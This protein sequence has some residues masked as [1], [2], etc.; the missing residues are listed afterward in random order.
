[1][2]ARDEQPRYQGRRRHHLLE[3][4]QHQQHL[5]V[6][7][8]LLQ[9]LG[10][11]TGRR[12][13][14]SHLLPYHDGDEVGLGDGSQRYEAHPVGELPE[15]RLR[16][17]QGQPGLARASGTSECDESH[18]F[19]QQRGPQRPHLPLASDERRELK[20]QAVGAIGAGF[21]RGCFS[22]RRRLESSSLLL[23]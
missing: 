14:D 2:G 15:Q 9:A 16:H 10:E 12:L 22:A 4:V 7:Q 6:P 8:V 19:S 21:G 13:R 17:S 5:P 23:R 18:V 11:R 20:R 3:V 1:M